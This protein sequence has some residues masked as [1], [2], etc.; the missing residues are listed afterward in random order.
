M[1][2]TNQNDS[3]EVLDPMEPAEIK[4]IDGTI[5]FPDYEEYRF[6]AEE[7]RNALMEM[8]V[9][10]DTEQKAKKAVAEARK[11]SDR[12]N[13][14]KIRIKKEIL[15]PYTDFES[16]VK[17][18]INIITEGEDIA[19]DKLRDIDTQRREEK[20]KTIE[21][22]WN[23]RIDR[24]TAGKYLDF[25]DFLTDKH[26]NKTVSIDAVEK[27]M[28]E[29]LERTSAE[30]EYLE[31]LPLSDLYIPEYKVTYSIPKAMETVDQRM[32]VTKKAAG[33]PYLIVKI[34]GKADIKLAKSWLEQNVE[35]KIMEEN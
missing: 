23:K 30:L 12:L 1:S 31:G 27:E 25:D 21:N 16:Q 4:V 14:E 24:F 32:T 34:T 22:I 5:N 17:T 6:R 15:A 20:R 33:E 7:I 26:L 8:P 11:I 2:Y 18:I 29:F 3:I 35:Y 19:R 13:S 28:V 9:S 10:V